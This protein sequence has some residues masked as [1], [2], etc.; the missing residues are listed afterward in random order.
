MF[1]SCFS[2]FYLSD[3][4]WSL[5]GAKFTALVSDLR[6]SHRTSAIDVVAMSLS[7]NWRHH[8]PGVEGNSVS[9]PFLSSASLLRLLAGN[10]YR[11]LMNRYL[12][13]VKCSTFIR[14]MGSKVNI[15]LDTFIFYPLRG[16]YIFWKTR[17]QILRWTCDSLSKKAY[18]I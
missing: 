3:F 11:H 16:D 7:P 4:L 17:S 9:I 13:S 18:S 6:F 2:F 12:L 5:K 10:F 1:L 8:P 15:Y 14:R